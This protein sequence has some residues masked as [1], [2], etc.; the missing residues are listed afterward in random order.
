MKRCVVVVAL[1]CACGPQVGATDD[2]GTSSDG[3][4]SPTTDTPTT[5][6]PTTDTPTTN[7]PTTDTPTTNTG[8]TSAETSTTTGDDEG[9]EVADDFLP[10]PPDTGTVTYECD[11]WAVQDCPRGQKCMPWSWDGSGSWNATKCTDLAE[12]PREDGESCTAF[13]GP[14]GGVDDCG[15]RSMCFWVDPRTNAG[16]CVAMCMGSRINPTCPD[17]VTWCTLP[18]D[19]LPAVCLPVCDPLVQDC[20]EGSACYFVHDRF[21]CDPDLSGEGGLPGD[22][23]DVPGDC[24]PGS[25]C[26]LG[27]AVPGCAT[28]TCCAAF[29]DLTA[30]SCDE[31]LEC[32]AW[33]DEGEAPPGEEDVGACLFQEDG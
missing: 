14:F 31:G 30:P 33:Y 13:E 7:T 16:E 21:E 8:A 20:V 28:Q 2:A 18:S 24:D 19:G 6:T 27:T 10:P 26:V 32:I 17:G 1:A 15:A 29:C 3:D 9:E 5:D 22:A 23:C 25:V 4:S 12:D 11:P